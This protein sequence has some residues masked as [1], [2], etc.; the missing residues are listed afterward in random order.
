MTVANHRTAN[1]LGSRITA[2]TLNTLCERVFLLASMQRPAYVCFATAHMLVETTRDAGIRAAYQNAQM[3]SPDGVPVTW[4][5]RMLGHANAECISGPRTLPVLLREATERGVRVGFYGGREETLALLRERITRELPTLEVAYCCS[6]PF[7]P[8]TTEEQ[9]QHIDEINSSGAQLLF[10]GLGSPKQECWMDRFSPR[11]NCV[12][13][14][15]GA[16][17]EFFSGEKVLPPVCIQ[18][19]GLTWFV[20][21]CQEPRRLARRN[22]YS[23]IFLMLAFRWT[24][25]NDARRNR[26]E[27]SMNHRLGGNISAAQGQPLSG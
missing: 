3:I 22:L 10:V 26:W 16:A 15:I 2:A 4:F 20:R 1:L 27:I 8:L 24:L 21:L 11:L 17:L 7:R 6:P 12:C 13:L 9:E 5:V 19:C 14:G 23:P 25:M 18:K